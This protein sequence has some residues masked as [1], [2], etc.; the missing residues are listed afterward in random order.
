ML[1]LL[2]TKPHQVHLVQERRFKGDEQHHLQ[3]GLRDIAAWRRKGN[4]DNL[5]CSFLT[6][7]HAVPVFRKRTRGIAF[8][9]QI[10][11]TERVRFQREYSALAEASEASE[12]TVDSDD[13][14]SD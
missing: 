10:S 1:K 2:R 3:Y 8:G 13:D 14:K 12:S 5:T 6:L 9:M 4:C 11:I 7:D